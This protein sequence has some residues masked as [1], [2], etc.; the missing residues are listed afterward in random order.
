M[1]KMR[2]Y[3]IL[4]AFLLTANT[5]LSIEI[6][7][8]TVQYFDSMAIVVEP[9]DIRP[10]VYSGEGSTFF[11]GTTG[12]EA[13]GHMGFWV[14]EFKLWDDFEIEVDSVLLDRGEATVEFKPHEIVFSWETGARLWIF[15]YF[16]DK[17]YIGFKFSCE[18][19]NSLA[20]LRIK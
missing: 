13:S 20:K 1:D 16:R 14:G 4:S 8:Y 5:V 3:T 9:G 17:N 18:K 15:P 7:A 6:P 2:F 11:Y 12:N 19:P 10:Y